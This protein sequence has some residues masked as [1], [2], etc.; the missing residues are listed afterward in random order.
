MRWSSL[1]RVGRAAAV[2]GAVLIPAS[3]ADAASIWTPISSGTSDTIS[4]I[5]YESPTRFW[6]ATTNGRIAYWNGS[7]FVAGSGTTPGENF[8]DLAFQPGTGGPG[9]AGVYGYAVTS[10]GH[11]WQ[12]K[13]GGVTWTLLATPFTLHDCGVAAASENVSE[14][15]AVVWASASTAYLLGNESTLERSN[16]ANSV[17]P[18]FAEINKV[19]NG[20][21][22]AQAETSTRNLTDAAFLPSNPLDGF[23]VSQDFGQIYGTSNAFVSGTGL[24]PMI[25][26][27]SGN[28][29]IAIDPSNLNRIWAVDH[30][31]GGGGCGTLC[32]A[33]STDGAQA[34]T[35]PNYPNDLHPSI[36]LYGVSSQGGIEV[37]AGSGGEL[38]NSVDGVSFYLQRADGAL[39]TENWRAEDA[40][41]ASHAAVGGESGALAVTAAADTIPDIVPPTGAVSGPTTVTSGR[42]ATFTA[43]VADNA[44]GSGI[45]PSGFTW[46][47]PGFPPQHG[48][49]A[50]YTFARGTRSATITLT[51]T[52][53][54]GN[55]A[56]SALTVTVKDAPLAAPSGSSPLT[57]HTGGATLTIFRIVTVSGR[58][59][60]FVP[61]GV[62]VKQGRRL[63]I[64]ILTLKHR[65]RVAKLNATLRRRGR[66]TLHIVL[67]ANAKPG[68]YLM[69]VRVL[70]LKG[71]RLGRTVTVSF[72]LL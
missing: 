30:A 57:V 42:P 63:A 55:Q 52:D 61:V 59:G 16:A 8:T 33:Y 43:A 39:A 35:N 4:A 68:K 67:P 56:T 70:T 7:S 18:A 21:C 38:F 3:A 65:H 25:N 28:P 41:D 5:S 13:D 15:N 17:T 1:T 32:F 69:L 37:A 40:Y 31:V 9:T 62:S 19:G 26:Y 24:A 44:G 20:T 14:F 50:I 12:T 47:T 23:M 72:S 66:S 11:L 36:G 10:S 53:N 48:A 45:N 6:Y 64:S 60:R 22:Q 46:V 27:F 49:S 34:F 29:R 2:L 54:A 51:F 71:H 58:N